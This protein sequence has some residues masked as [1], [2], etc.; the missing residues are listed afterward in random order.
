LIK[1]DQRKKAEM[2]GFDS[3]N[4]KHPRFMGVVFKNMEE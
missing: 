4:F 3:N 2:D 1:S